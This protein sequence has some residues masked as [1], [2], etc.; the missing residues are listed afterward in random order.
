MNVSEALLVLETSIT[1]HGLHKTKL[2]YFNTTNNFGNPMTRTRNVHRCQKRRSQSS[3]V[4]RIRNKSVANQEAL[5][6][7]SVILIRAGFA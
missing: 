3:F 2:Q 4:P 6:I 5:R 7:A 1:N